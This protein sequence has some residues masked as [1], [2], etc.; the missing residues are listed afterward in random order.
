MINQSM[1][2]LVFLNHFVSYTFARLLS[3]VSGDPGM[4][5]VSFVSNEARLEMRLFKF[6]RFM[7]L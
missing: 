1:S 7:S 4:R 3:V 5:E 6:K 2:Y